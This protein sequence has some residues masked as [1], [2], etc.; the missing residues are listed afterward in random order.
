MSLF[1][2]SVEGRAAVGRSLEE[3]AHHEKTKQQSSPGDRQPPGALLHTKKGHATP[4]THTRRESVARTLSPTSLAT[5]TP[6]L[7]ANASA[8]RRSAARPRAAA[9]TAAAASAS[10][11]AAMA[12]A[13]T[14][15]YRYCCRCCCS[16]MGGRAEVH[17]GGC[18]GCCEGCPDA[19]LQCGA[20]R[21][22]RRQRPDHGASPCPA[23][24]LDRLGMAASRLLWIVY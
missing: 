13:A 10:A 6:A 17:T 7:L 3:S 4:E 12:A 14:A 15:I 21:C 20:A 11:A 5:M 8:K 24:A 1:R 16:G 2:E 23:A 22:H 18:T 9:A 19:A